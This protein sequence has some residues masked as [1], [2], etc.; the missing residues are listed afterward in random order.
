MLGSGTRV[1]IEVQRSDQDDHLRRV[2]FNA[3]SITVKESNTGEK[4]ENVLDLYVVY[5]SEKD[6]FKGNRT[7]YHVEKIL[8]ETGEPVEDGLHEIFVN[9]AVFDGTD[10]AELMSCFLKKEVNHPKFPRLS[11]E[12]N[13]IKH[14]EGGVDVMCEVMQRYETIAKEEGRREGRVEGRREGRVEGRL[15]LIA[16]MLMSGKTAQEIA[17]FTGISPDEIEK[18]KQ[19]ILVNV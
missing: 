7:I 8:R 16:S 15:Q 1:N 12:V 17:I 4:F 6:I 10:I 19:S 2:R 5:I 18:A 13:R 9:T 3:S 14:T 11:N